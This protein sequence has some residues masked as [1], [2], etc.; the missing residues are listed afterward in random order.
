M[1]YSTSGLILRARPYGE[2]DRLFTVFTREQGKTTFL[3]RGVRK[4]KSKL[5]RKLAFFA[6]LDFFLAKGRRWDIVAGV[7]TG[8]N[9]SGILE[10]FGRMSAGFYFLELVDRFLGEHV[11]DPR[12]YEWILFGL[13]E[14]GSWE[15]NEK[16]NHHPMFIPIM[17]LR[18]LAYLGY[19]PH[20]EDCARCHGRLDLSAL[21]MSYLDG[22]VLCRD[23]QQRGGEG[24]KI[25]GDDILFL[26][27]IKSELW[28]DSIE[29]SKNKRR[30]SLLE[31]VPSFLRFRLEQEMKTQKFI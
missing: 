28:Q 27:S 30:P 16:K 2:S 29:E 1:T 14:I 5:S 17:T 9:Y 22:G 23:C 10:G 24:I 13:G 12:V 26:E 8:S 18:L 20:L 6:E 7:E 31:L 15:K 11:A 4:A 19:Y 25:S 3:A 21:F